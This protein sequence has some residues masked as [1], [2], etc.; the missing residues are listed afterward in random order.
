MDLPI[1]RS[2]VLGSGKPLV[3]LHAFPLSH[4]IWKN[5]EPP[6]GYSLI[7][8][9]F[10]GFGDSPLAPEGLTLEA[11]AQGLEGHLREL[12]LKGPVVLGGISMG[13]Y[14][15]M[16]FLRQFPAQVNKVLFISTRSGVDKPEARE[17]RL[18]MAEKVL[19][20]GTEFMVDAMV[21]GLLGKTTLSHKPE[22]ADQ[23]GRWIRA[24]H[25][26]A[27]ALAQRAMA[28]RRDQASLLPAL[29]VPTLILAGREDALIPV[30]ESEAMAQA[31]RVSQLEVLEGAGHLLPLEDPI[32]FQK[33]LDHF[34]SKTL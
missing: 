27:V 16:E 22:V 18:K 15:A 8:P 5:M 29:R 12:Q 32:S 30:S 7:L 17:N 24:T 3:L 1:L 19:R 14:W 34:L 33:I 11:A 4:Q 26:G 25:P 20:E 21:P 28:V 2:K 23:V 9:D 31:V 10:P 6:K 13:G